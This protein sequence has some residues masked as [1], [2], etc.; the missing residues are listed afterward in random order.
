MVKVAVVALDVVAAVVVVDLEEVR[1]R[2]GRVTR[3]LRRLYTFSSNVMR[4]EKRRV[5]N[6]VAHV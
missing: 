5:P 6:V 3:T 4:F 2:L 1:R